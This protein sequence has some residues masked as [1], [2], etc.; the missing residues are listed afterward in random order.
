M[1]YVRTCCAEYGTTGFLRCVCGCGCKG[2]Y[3][4][5]GDTDVSLT[6]FS[7]FAQDFLSNRHKRSQTLGR[8]DKPDPTLTMFNKTYLLSYH[9][10][11]SDH[12]NCVLLYIKLLFN[13]FFLFRLQVFKERTCGY[14]C[15]S[16]VHRPR[17][18]PQS[19]FNPN[20]SWGWNMQ[21]SHRE[22]S[23]GRTNETTQSSGMNVIT[24]RVNN[25]IR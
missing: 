13:F 21:N 19:G 17:S 15:Y 7:L 24:Y 8:L 6:F 25:V 4:C 2:V 9:N 14:S 3:V 12:Q 18:H 5:S 11:A 16:D 20:I 23:C 10:S 1:S 22:H